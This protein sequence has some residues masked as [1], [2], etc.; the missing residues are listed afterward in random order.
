MMTR[1]LILMFTVL[2]ALLAGGCAGQYIQNDLYEDELRVRNTEDNVD[3]TQVVE[4]YGTALGELNM[5]AI[6]ALLSDDYYENGGTTDT[7]I[8]DF[9]SEGVPAM[10]AMLADHVEE[11]NIALA[12]REIVVDGDL[13]DVLFEYTIRARYEVAGESRW[14]TERDVNRLQ[15][16]RENAGWKI[17]SGL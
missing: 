11:M 4:N 16:Q 2:G 10:L 6:E 8:D 9:G 5:N 3:I 13:A 14:E 12:I 7:T 15:L 17:I 1:Q